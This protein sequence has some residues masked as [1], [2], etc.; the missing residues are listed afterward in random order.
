MKTGQTVWMDCK[1]CTTPGVLYKRPSFNSP[2]SLPSPSSVEVECDV[3]EGLGIC[4]AGYTYNA[5][6]VFDSYKV[7]E[8]LDATE[9]NG[10]TD[11]QKDGVLHLLTCGLVDLN[12]GKAGRVRLW[13]WFGGEST[14]VTNL[15]ELL[16]QEDT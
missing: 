11:T 3:C 10:L 5:T 15:T 9:H 1:R 16:A 4:V 12:E 14:T 6:N 13:N 8:C 7:L 2:E